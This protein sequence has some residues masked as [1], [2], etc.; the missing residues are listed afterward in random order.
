MQLE[1]EGIFMEDATAFYLGEITLALGH[2]HKAG[3]I[4]RDLKPE[5]IMLDAKGVLTLP[6]IILRENCLVLQVTSS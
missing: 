6:L 1:R 4:Y 3:V 5:N 2:L